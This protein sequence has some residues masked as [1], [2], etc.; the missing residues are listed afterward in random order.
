MIVQMQCK[1][2]SV[3]GLHIGAANVRRHFRGDARSIEFKLEDL[4]IE[5]ELKPGFWHDEPEITDPRLC[6]WLEARKSQRESR[7][8]SPRVVMFPSGKRSFRLQVVRS[9]PDEDHSPPEPAA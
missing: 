6:A 3:I 5:C 9:E 4:R 1:G 8:A 7:R 2:R